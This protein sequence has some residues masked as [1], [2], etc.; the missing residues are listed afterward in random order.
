MFLFSSAPSTWLQGLSS[1][2]N[3]VPGAVQVIRSAGSALNGP[4]QGCWIA[5]ADTQPQSCPAP[6][7][8][9]GTQPPA[10]ANDSSRSWHLMAFYL[11][12][13]CQDSKLL[14]ENHTKNLRQNITLNLYLISLARTTS[15]RSFSLHTGNRLMPSFFISL[16]DLPLHKIYV[17][18]KGA[19][20]IFKGRTRTTFHCKNGSSHS[21][22]TKGCQASRK[23]LTNCSGR[24]MGNTNCKACCPSTRTSFMSCR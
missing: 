19:V 17:K 22:F 21:T 3:L 16:W 14:A 1:P 2:G 18:D 20:I 6:V 8:L 11:H 12:S 10:A 15:A 13:S 5:S 23:K 9:V 24:Q 4:A 7:G